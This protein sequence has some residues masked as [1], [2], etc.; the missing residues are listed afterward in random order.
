M[1]T[2]TG[3]VAGLDGE[4]IDEKVE[5][6]NVTLSAGGVSPSSSRPS[7]GCNE[8][9]INVVKRVSPNLANI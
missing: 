8:S 4:S 1:A 7:V 5:V 2:L 6:N 9:C 3:G